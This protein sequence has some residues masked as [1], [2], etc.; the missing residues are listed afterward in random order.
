MEVLEASDSL[1]LVNTFHILLTLVD[2]FDRLRMHDFK[3]A[4]S[5]I[6]SLFL[7]PLSSDDLQAKVSCYSLMDPTVRKAFPS[8]L[9]GVIDALHQQFVRTR[10][11]GKIEDVAFVEE[12]RKELKRK[13]SLITSFAGA[14]SMPLDLRSRIANM[15][16][17]MI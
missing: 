5:I 14:L 10:Y 16:A 13:A 17:Q 4:T 6:E 9:E 11:T 1:L 15:E 12:N 8:V 3:K 2:F 7:L